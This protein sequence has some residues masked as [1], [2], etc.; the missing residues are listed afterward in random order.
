MVQRTGEGP[1]FRTE[2]LGSAGQRLRKRIIEDNLYLARFYHTSA[3]A[4]LK[5]DK[6]TT[7]IME[8]ETHLKKNTN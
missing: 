8:R 4:K 1:V 2:N 5:K 6:T 3:P 7:T